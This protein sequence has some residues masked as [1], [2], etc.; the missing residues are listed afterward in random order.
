MSTNSN[1]YSQG[2]GGTQFE[3]EVHT[4]YFI[5]LLIGGYFPGTHGKIVLYRQQSGSLGYKT[6]DLL[7]KTEDS[8]GSLARHL[9]QI[10]H[11]LVISESNSI[12]LG[13]A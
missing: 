2:G 13:P 8:Q 1:L 3:F 6:D 12:A 5:L 9:F 11:G 10:K 4:A 7:L